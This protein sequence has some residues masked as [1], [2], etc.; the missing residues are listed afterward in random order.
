MTLMVLLVD[1]LEGGVVFAGELM[2]VLIES[3]LGA[4]RLTLFAKVEGLGRERALCRLD[5]D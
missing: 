2:E 3:D 4:A 5:Q 1:L